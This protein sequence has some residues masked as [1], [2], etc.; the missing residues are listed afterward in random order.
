MKSLYCVSVVIP[1]YNVE[2]YVEKCITSVLRQTLGGFEMILVDDCGTD[3]SMPVIEALLD[4]EFP[5]GVADWIRIMH[6]PHNSGAGPTRN[7]GMDAACGEYIAF[8]DGDDYIEEDYLEALYREA[9]KQDAD[10]AY[11]GFRQVGPDGTV[12][13][14]IKP[15]CT[16]VETGRYRMLSPYSHLYRRSFLERLHARFPNV[17]NQ[18]VV[19]NLSVLGYTDRV[20]VIPDTGYCYVQR[21]GSAV[22]QGNGFY[23]KRRFPFHELSRVLLEAKTNGLSGRTY[24]RLEYEA[25]KCYAAMM[26][27]YMRRCNKKRLDS[28]ADTVRECLDAAAPRCYQNPFLP[29]SALPALPLKSRLGTFL[30]AKAYQYHCLKQFAWLITRL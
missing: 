27:C 2:P 11:C 23:V 17:F 3:R 19:F 30:F 18:D 24:T 10:V 28:H 5:D 1:V 25:V 9:K 20:A 14:V 12:L 16:D 22:H 26:L 29:I 8:I 4:R 13:R 6:N 7:N 21:P 15:E